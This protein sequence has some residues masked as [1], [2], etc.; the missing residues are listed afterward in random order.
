MKTLGLDLGT[1]SIGWALVETHGSKTT[2]LNKGVHLFEKGVGENQTGEY[3]L[4]AERTR[5]RSAR[6]IK[7][8]RKWRKQNTLNILIEHGYCPGITTEDI[9]RW[10][11]EKVFPTSPEFRQWLHTKETTPEGKPAGPYLYRW[12]AATKAYDLAK[13]T[14]RHQLGRAFYHLAQ[15]RGYRSNRISGEE[16]E[17]DVMGAIQKLD[18]LRAGRTLGQ[19]YYEEC[20][21]KESV[22]GA[23]HYTS[24]K[25]YE[26]EFEV[27]VKRQGIPAGLSEALFKA[28]FTQRP[29]RSQK[30]TVGKCPLEPT[31][32]RAPISHPL[33]ER[34]RAL[35][36]VNNIRIAAPGEPVLRPLNES[37]RSI[38]L[39]FLLDLKKNELFEKL[40]KKLTPKKAQIAYGGLKEDRDISFWAFNYRE[41]MDVAQSPVTARLRDLF[42][43]DWPEA[44]SK[45]YTKAAGK[46][47]DQVVDD[48]WHVLFSFR[49]HDKLHAFA[50]TQLGL[51]EE[52]A[53]KFSRPVP[54]GYANLSLCA[55]RKIVP[56]LEKGLMY[57]HAVF[58]ANLA[59]ILE[60]H[61]IRWADEGPDLEAT[62]GSLLDSHWM[63]VRCS[64]AVN[65]MLAQSREERGDPAAMRATPA[66]WNRLQKRMDE[67]ICGS[68]GKDVWE[69]LATDVRD[70]HTAHCVEELCRLYPS[71]TFAKV[72]TIEERIADLLGKRYGLDN[73]AL[74]RI[75]HPSAIET[76]PKARPD[77]EGAWRLGSPRIASIKNPVFM[78]TMT[79]LRHLINTML[80]DG[81]IDPGTKIRIEM[82]RDLNTQN[83][84]AAIDRE[85]RQRTSE[86]AEYREKI[87]EAGFPATDAN[88][89]KYRLW[90]EQEKKCIYT[91]KEISLTG[92]LGENPAFDIEHTMPRSRILDNSQS[93][94]TLCDRYFNREK[95]ENRIP[96]ELH[97]AE[98]ILQRARLL[99]APKIEELDGL[100]EKRKAAAR[101]APTKEAKDKAR[102]DFLF[103]RN[104]LRYWR[105]KLKLFELTEIPDGF[106]NSQLVDTRLICKYAML[107][108]KSLFE[109]VYSV[110]AEVVYGVKDIWDLESKYRGN[111]VHHCVDAIVTACLRPEFY[112][113][114]AAYYREYERYERG[115]GTRPHVPEPWPGFAQNLNERLPSEV[116][117]V[118]YSKA[119]L[120]NPTFKKLRVRGV[121]QKR[122]DG[123]PVMLQGNSARGAL[124]KDT[125]YGVI[126]EPPTAENKDAR[127]KICVVR[128]KLDKSFKDFDK[129]VD[130]AVRRIVEASRDRLN[131]GE[132]V[133][134]D[135]VRRIPINYVRVRVSNKPE[136]LIP[137]AKHAYA[138]RQSYKA[139]K[140]AANDGNYVTGLYRGTVNG[141][142]KSD[143]K[144]VT[145]FEAVEATRKDAWE[146]ILPAIDEKGLHLRYT[147]KAGSLVFFC[148]ESVDELKALT[149]PELVTRLYRV[150]VMEGSTAQFVYHACGLPEKEL[151][152]GTSKIAWTGAPKPK[153]RLSVNGII[154]ALAGRDFILDATGGINWLEQKHA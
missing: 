150:T 118:H 90:I 95:K 144:I 149:H 35:Q 87:K 145:N 127:P 151:G 132:T 67:A 119:T 128:K 91:G 148:K 82:A 24:R 44:L 53:K 29:L 124:H 38:A 27:I 2:L 61:G 75:Y 12:Q 64:L 50:Q 84:R 16:R 17:G 30:G 115:E 122:A 13:P 105:R 108:L 86:N 23:T 117:C 142:A 131:G 146:K 52:K 56:H 21:G 96:M 63:D 97:G 100:A 89:L 133:W 111:H 57:A 70:K 104:Q 60:K 103:L 37:E 22:R 153:L 40:A 8:R 25:Q 98:E 26:D 77:A 5:Y 126:Q 102:A 81:L 55:L 11:D 34:Y 58:L 43:A 112:Q 62:I 32:A 68:A 139:H 6:R 71:E 19:Y 129:I 79:R 88:V 1:N 18:E 15:R 141:K 80:K 125:C 147:L 135:E 33:F 76:Y 4:A 138:S 143:W 93:N 41:D 46:S 9:R 106:S 3:S 85:Q 47:P 99:W 130:P 116:L 74:S 134:F 109:K 51:D 92:F 72:A 45:C 113:D 121:V 152:K 140:Y 42:G 94:L 78:R 39:E 66:T 137:I 7:M 48:I 28:I 154:I 14:D 114:I 31:K 36:T 120:L 49:D 107:Y 73:R 136:S 123:S 65:A 69:S 54:Q 10:R 20:L 83:D 59:T 110:K 101:R